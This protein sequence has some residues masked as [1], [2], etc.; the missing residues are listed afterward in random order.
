MARVELVEERL[1]L[2]LAAAELPAV[3]A[4][5]GL[6]PPAVADREVERAVG[7]GLHARGAARLEPAHGRVQPHVGAL[8]ERAREGHVVVLEE[9]D[10][11]LEAL[12]ACQL[13]DALDELLA[14]A[15]VR[16]GLAGEDDAHGLGRIGEQL[17]QPGRILEEERGALVGREAARE[18]DPERLL[19][20][21]VQEPRQQG[22]RVSPDDEG[23]RKPR[24]HLGH[25]GDDAA[26]ACS[27]AVPGAGGSSAA[28]AK[29]SGSRPRS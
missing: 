25:R 24:A 28:R 7:G 15:V 20:Q 13:E 11:A 19:V 10:L 4:I 6:G 18:A 23:A 22:R 14:D 26:R 5:E 3:L 8:H 17:G 16:V 27:R 2:V 9:E 12:L 1:V 29:S 21:S